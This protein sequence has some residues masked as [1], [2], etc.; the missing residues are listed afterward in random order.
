MSEQIFK[1][2]KYNKDSIIYLEKSKPMPYLYIIKSGQVNRMIEFLET[3]ENE[4][5]HEGD[6]FGLVSCLTGLNS[7]ERI[8]AITDCE[9]IIV[10]K[11]NLIPFLSQK[12]EIF[13][14]VIK[15]Y[16]NRLRNLDAMYNQLLSVN[17]KINETEHILYA[18][19]FFT[20]NGEEELANLVYNIYAKYTKRELTSFDVYVG[21]AVIPEFRVGEKI[22]LKKNKIVFI[23]GETGD[24]FFYID[25]G[26][27]K[28]SHYFEDK[29]LIL[30][31]L[32][33]GEFF[34]EMSILNQKSRMASA[35]VFEDC[36]LLILNQENFMDK[37]GNAIL[38]KIFVS[39]A[40]RFY[41]TY[42]RVVNLTYKNPLSRVYDCLDYLIDI[43]SG[44]QRETAFH[45]YF[46][47]DEIKRMTDTISLDNK[48]IYEFLKD[49]NIKFSPG[50][51][52]IINLDKF[53]AKLRKYTGKSK[54]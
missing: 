21:K 26:K 22:K 2:K 37:L 16:S 39:L 13:L 17:Q 1:I 8:T 30:S 46:S 53:Y 7:I 43:K 28:I 23:E 11:K 36:E 32:G 18:A 20:K 47:V 9:V 4:T 19:K 38:Q 52:V 49:E 25:K 6:N 24:N 44:I 48:Y 12:K 3:E 35:T 14:K 29:E 41:H 15:D 5:L 33:E 34:G 42:R 45:F 27:I 10:D 51:M 31:I 54:E 50:E 40:T